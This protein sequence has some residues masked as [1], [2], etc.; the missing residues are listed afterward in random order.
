[1][2]TVWVLAWGDLDNA[3]QNHGEMVFDRQ[4][5]A[6]EQVRIWLEDEPLRDTV[7]DCLKHHNWSKAY[8]CS[9]GWYSLE[10]QQIRTE[11]M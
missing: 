3:N 4:E 11:V 1:M 8:W 7:V 10:E 6:L 9:D 2:N 5:T